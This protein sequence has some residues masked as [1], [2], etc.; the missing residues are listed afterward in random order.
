VALTGTGTVMNFSPASLDFGTLSKG[1]AS[2]PQNITVTNLG[3]TSVSITKISITGSR[4][5]SFSETNNCP[6]TLAANANC[7]ISVVFT[8]QLKGALN[9]DVTL[10]DTGGG[11]P[12]NVPIAGTG[13]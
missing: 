4:V 1:T 9:A 13:D 5:T 2:Q 7:T 10:L 8:P 3:T 12:Q 11:S 6:A